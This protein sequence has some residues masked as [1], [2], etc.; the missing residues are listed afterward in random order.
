LSP[1]FASIEAKPALIPCIAL[2]T[3]S[4]KFEIGRR[5]YP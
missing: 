3:L 2:S 5:C 4:L 1:D